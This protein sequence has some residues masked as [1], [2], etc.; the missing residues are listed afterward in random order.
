MA[1][2]NFKKFLV[3]K[4]EVKRIFEELERYQS[5]CVTYGFAFD[6][7]HLGNEYSPYGDYVR[8]QHG[9]LPRDNW[10]WMCRQGRKNYNPD[11]QQ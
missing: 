10:G 11:H 6:E 9:R 3:M 4:P 7:S 8:S 1:R 2:E 5:F